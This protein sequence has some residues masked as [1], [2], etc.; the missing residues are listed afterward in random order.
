M[1]VDR[2]VSL[3]AFWE[4]AEAWDEVNC[5]G[6]AGAPAPGV[7]KSLIDRLSGR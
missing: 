5:G 1:V 6:P 7:C 2:K 4:A 3:A